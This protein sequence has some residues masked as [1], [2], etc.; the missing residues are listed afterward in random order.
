V[1]AL[2]LVA[3]AR[4][5]TDACP[6]ALRP[7]SAAD[8][9]LLRLRVP[10]GSLPVASLVALSAA[11]E[12]FGDGRIGLTSRG[13][14]QVRGIKRPDVEELVDHVRSAGLL[15]SI[16]HE[17]VRNVVASPL[18][19]RSASSVTDVDA[20]VSALD[21]ALCAEPSL[22]ALPGRFLFA[23]DDGSG[24]VAGERADVLVRAVGRGFAV[25]PA[26]GDHGVVVSRADAVAAALAVA[27]LFQAMRT[28][29]WRVRELPE[30]S[31]R[32]TAALKVWLD[33]AG[34][35]WKAAS[36]CFTA[37]PKA[38]PGLAEQRD[39]R[40]AV[41]ASVPL[42][43]LTAG[44]VAALAAALA[45]ADPTRLRISPWRQVVVR[46]LEL[47][48]AF[49][50]REALVAAGLV[51][52]PG[53]AW[54]RL[55]ACAGRPGCAKSLT[56]VHADARRFAAACDQDG[57]AVHFVGCA[58]ACGTPS[59]RVVTVEATP[60]GYRADGALSSRDAAIVGAR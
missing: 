7:H 16:S 29:E 19:G 26:S 57:P 32:L 8:G 46:D 10:G 43:L 25:R 30:G 34:L 55:T 40:F 23:V 58:R 6:G 42:G 35:P 60:D 31:A 56:D 15:P 59:G 5:R 51:V 1:S 4:S 48:A 54:G 33:E 11:A 36:P 9:Q 18:S 47:K 53:S 27:E 50:V 38:V 24:A 41:V 17:L 12:A 13:N 2:P 44:H 22:S 20:V 52:R 39:G 28:S 14:V 45:P 49:A 21:A 3:A 37:G